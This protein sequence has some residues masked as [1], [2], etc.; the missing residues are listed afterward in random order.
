ME[1]AGRGHAPVSAVCLHHGPYTATITPNGGYL[2]LA[3][4]YW[5]MVKEL[6]AFAETGVLQVMVKG[7]DWMPGSLLADGALQA[8]GLPRGNCPLGCSAR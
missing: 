1:R 2:D 8:V 5:N 6:A 4:L 3:T 7:T